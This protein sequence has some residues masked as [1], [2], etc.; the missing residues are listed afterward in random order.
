MDEHLARKRPS[1]CTHFQMC[2]HLSRSGTHYARHVSCEQHSICQQLN[3]VNF[4]PYCDSQSK[5]CPGQRRKSR[6]HR[7]SPVPRPH[8]R[9]GGGRG[10]V[11]AEGAP[12]RTPRKP[13]PDAQ[14]SGSVAGK[15]GHLAAASEAYGGE[16]CQGKEIRLRGFP[17]P[18]QDGWS[19]SLRGGIST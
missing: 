4:I 5:S 6:R 19:S 16:W 14:P 9:L 10:G 13:A 2:T 8:P 3:T 18:H 17:S 1:V 7:G 12:S 11:P 15:A